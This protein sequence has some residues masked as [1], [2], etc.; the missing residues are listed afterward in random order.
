MRRKYSEMAAQ[1]DLYSVKV[2]PSSLVVL[3]GPAASGKSSWAKKHFAT[4]QIVSSDALRSTVADDEAMQEASADAFMLLHK[5]VEARLRRGLVTVV[6][7]TALTTESRRKLLAIAAAYGRSA[8]AVIFQIDEK[9][10]YDWNDKRSR[11]VNQRVLHEHRELAADVMNHLPNEGFS[12]Y[13]TIHS[14]QMMESTQVIRNIVDDAGPFDIIGDVHGCYSELCDL[15]LK[16]GYQQQSPNQFLWKHP[17]NRK[18][19]FVGDLC[20]RGPDT[21]SVIR[22]AMEMQKAC[23]AWLV[24]GNHDYKIAIK[25]DTND[26]LPE[27]PQNAGEITVREILNASA[28]SPQLKQQ[29]IHLLKFAPGYLIFDKGELV[30]T[31]GGILDSMIGSWSPRIKSFCMYGEV[32]SPN[33]TAAVHLDWIHRRQVHKTSPLIVYGHTPMQNPFIFNKTV[34]IDTGCCYGGKLTAYRYPEHITVSVSAKASYARKKRK[35][36]LS[37]KAIA[38]ERGAD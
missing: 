33:N 29:I 4:S 35:N 7:S 27:Q 5:I 28:N 23:L 18:L 26:P 20:D 17:Q 38:K 31:H 22:L 16:L 37:E 14:P 8:I 6:D 15:L 36:F 3:V 13:Y 1:P 25:I 2:P 21:V 10:Q 9:T 32:F 34:D 30:I 24:Q 12:A 11:S 19:V